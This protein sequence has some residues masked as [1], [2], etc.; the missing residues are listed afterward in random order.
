MKI[1]VCLIATGRYMEFVPKLLTDI[2]KHF[3]PC[4]IDPQVILFSDGAITD[5]WNLISIPI[6]HEPWPL[7]TLHRYH[8]ML[9]AYGKLGGANDYVFYMDVDMRIEAPI[10]PEVLGDLV[11]V[12]HPGY[13]GRPLRSWLPHEARVESA[14]YVPVSARRNYFA[15]GFQGG[16]VPYYMA[17][18]AQLA[19]M[20]QA[21]E[22]RGMVPTWHDES[23]WNWFL[24][25]PHQPTTILNPSYCYSRQHPHP[26]ITPRIVTIEKDHSLYR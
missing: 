21:E 1:T 6:Q 7:V 26:G 13:F 19:S 22:N 16:S 18:C 14:F 3:R 5:H 23:A 20:I 11:A 4:D 9:R 2:R 12:Q 25:V 17:A 10:L 8:T 24:S 15:G